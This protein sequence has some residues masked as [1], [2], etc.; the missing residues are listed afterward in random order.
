VFSGG[1]WNSGPGRC[2]PFGNVL[3]SQ[4]SRSPSPHH[5]VSCSSSSFLLLS[6]MLILS[7]ESPAPTPPL[8]C[9]SSSFSSPLKL[10]G[11][12]CEGLP[13]HILVWPMRMGSAVLHGASGDWRRSQSRIWFRGPGC[14]ACHV[15]VYGR[16]HLLLGTCTGFGPSRPEN[17]I[18]F[19]SCLCIFLSGSVLPFSYSVISPGWAPCGV[20]CY[21]YIVY[22]QRCFL[23]LLGRDHSAALCFLGC[24]ACFPLLSFSL[25]ASS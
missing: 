16:Q 1:Q 12:L 20:A 19:L 9:S 6:H 24:L 3:N 13:I 4:G 23:T 25:F 8:N 10:F 14:T 22:G 18:H 11:Y 7:L 15:A 21:W 17:S 5:S 2:A